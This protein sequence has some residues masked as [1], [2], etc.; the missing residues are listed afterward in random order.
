MLKFTKIILINFLIVFLLLEILSFFLIK[1]NILPNGVTPNLIFYAD[2]KLSYWHP[3][4]STF[5]IATK[6]WS[7]KVRFNNYGLKSDNN[8]KIEKTK[9]RIAILGDSMTENAQLS[10]DKDFTAKLQKLLPD[11][12][13][14]NFSVSSTG[15]ADHIRI[16]NRL[17]DKF[18]IDY[19]FYYVTLN[20]FSDNHISKKRDN[21]IT[22]AVSNEKPFE[23]DKDKS[24]FFKSY[25]S[26][27]NKFKR[28]KLIFLKNN[29]KIFI[30]Y[31]EIKLALIYRGDNKK[32]KIKK[33]IKNNLINE[34]AI[35]Y[36]Y[37]VNKANVEIFQKV[38]TLIFLNS[39]NIN[40]IEETDEIKRIKKILEP[41]NFYDPR[42]EFIK[43]LKQKK[44]LK[45]PYLGYPCDFHYSELGANLLANY[46]FKIFEEFLKR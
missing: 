21:R 32:L 38:P 25:N 27:W 19:L 8:L 28:E 35:V 36:K 23:I 31:Y 6:C 2:E 42:A 10:N 17:I 34:K 1:V 43:I 16:Y 7:S 14:L 22:Y 37:L 29:L 20:D 13:I 15:L 5:N 18:N 39:D 11:F 40:F 3:K 26:S 46:T 9:K 45:K 33:K 30:L 41:F 12:E 4:N 24:E 44:M